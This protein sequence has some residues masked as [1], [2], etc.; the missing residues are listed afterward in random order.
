MKI[1]H[2]IEICH[3]PKTKANQKRASMP[4]TQS[5]TVL[6][7]SWQCQQC[8]H[9]NNSVKNKKPCGSCRAWRD[10]IAPLSMGAHG[11]VCIKASGNGIVGNN[12]ASCTGL[13]FYSRE[14]N[15]PYKTSPCKDRMS[16]DKSGEKKKF[17]S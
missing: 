3:Q 9:A 6:T 12:A 13:L 5:A 8:C 14:N 4:R 11:E 7:L 1:C 10:G 2:W 17:P 16:Q 15:S